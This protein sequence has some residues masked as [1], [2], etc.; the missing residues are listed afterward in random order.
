VSATFASFG[1]LSI[2]DL[3]FVDGTTQ[4]AVPGGNAVYAALGMALWGE[5]PRVIAPF[6]P[7]YPVEKLHGRLDLSGC[8]R[9]PR[10]LRDWGLYEDDGSRQFV[11]RSTTKRWDDF[12]PRR[13]DVSGPIP[14]AHLAPLPWD[15]HV[16]LIE[17][18][19]EAGTGIVSIDLDD[20]N[21]AAVPLHDVARLIR[22]VDL[23]MPSQQ[24]GRVIFPTS[25]PADMVRRFRDM[26]PDTR[27]I[28]V[29][30]GA[31]GCVAHAAPS[32]DLMILPAFPAIAVDATGCGDCFCG[33]ALVGYER[34]ADPLQAL[35]HGA[36]AASFCVETVGCSGL[37]AGSPD[38]AS[39]RLAQFQNAVETKAA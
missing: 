8:P 1:N 16:E 14:A 34:T 35:L 28:A 39:A 11:F 32:Q 21:L 30:C 24:D 20:R 4:W 13:T 7:D 27:L 5:R 6:G 12:S 19:R 9:I 18:L 17:A 36:V 38:G 15:R 26:A 37:L 10:T 29:K 22:S 3:V 25:S 2:D 31:D 33:G 23:F